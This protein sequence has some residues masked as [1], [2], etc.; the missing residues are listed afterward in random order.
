MDEIELYTVLF[1][2]GLNFEQ[3]DDLK[4]KVLDGDRR[5]SIFA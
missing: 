1:V 3:R 4:S 2:R 5:G